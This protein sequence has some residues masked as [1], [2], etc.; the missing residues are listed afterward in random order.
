[1]RPISCR[2]DINSRAIQRL[3]YKGPIG[4]GGAFHACAGK[5]LFWGRFFAPL[6][7]VIETSSDLSE[8]D[9]KAPVQ[10]PGLCFGRERLTVAGALCGLYI[11]DP[12]FTWISNVSENT[13][14]QH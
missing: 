12:G 3:S 6:I 1:M 13:F 14:E 9:S 5:S 8:S 7:L 2:T 4:S 11:V 10:R